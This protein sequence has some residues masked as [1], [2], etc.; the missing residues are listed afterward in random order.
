MKVLGHRVELGEVEAKIRKASGLDGVVAIGWPRTSSGFGGI[1][2]FI[3]GDGRA[4]DQL[5]KD[6]ERELPDYMMPRR[7]HFMD[8]LP[9]NANDKF[10]RKAMSALLENGL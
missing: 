3:E 5:Q 4:T 8:R 6:L 2:V 7:F 9:R 1:E 10:D